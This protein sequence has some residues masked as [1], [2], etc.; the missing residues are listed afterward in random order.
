MINYPVILC[1]LLKEGAKSI[2]SAILCCCLLAV[3]AAPTAWAQK[4]AVMT[5]IEVLKERKFD[6]LQGKRVGLI[7]N[8]TGVDSAMRSTIDILFNAPSVKLV[9]LFGPEHG[10]RGD[11][12]AG[13]TVG[14]STDAVTGLPV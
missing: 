1:N 12:F 7:T 13:E 5:G 10:I 4:P 9:A 2:R 6:V 3:I 11:V 8:P 14:N